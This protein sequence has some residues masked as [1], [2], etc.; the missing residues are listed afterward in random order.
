[1]SKILKNAVYIVF[2]GRGY[3]ISG[4]QIR[5]KITQMLQNRGEISNIQRRIE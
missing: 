2:S 3:S 5:E 1:V 4:R